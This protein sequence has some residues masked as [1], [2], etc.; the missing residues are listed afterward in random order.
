MPSWEEV[1]R[2][3]PELATAV[4]ER[5]DAHR[6]KVLATLRA[7]GSP[8]LSGIE[9]TFK[10]GEVWLGMMPR[11]RK[12]VDLQRDPRLAL[13]SATTDPELAGGDAR[14]SGRAIHVT[15]PG[16]MAELVAGDERHADGPPPGEV[17]R[18]DVDE[19][20]WVRVDVGA[21]QLVIESWRDGSSVRRVERR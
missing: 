16:A 3:A 10:D 14:I 19:I 15:E 13:H 5:F 11:S 20:V 7:D 12:S 8:R 9:V 4:R 17:Y 1:A 21:D 2:A 18:V 6:H